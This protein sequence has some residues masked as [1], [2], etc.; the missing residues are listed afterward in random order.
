[1]KR[2]GL[3]FLVL[4]G[5]ASAGTKDNA[6]S[7]KKDVPAADAAIA[8]IPD[9]STR[10]AVADAAAPPPERVSA[11]FPVVQGACPPARAVLIGTTP[12]LHFARA[13]WALP[14]E[15]P[16]KL[17]AQQPPPHYS[18]FVG[19]I[20][21]GDWRLAAL[22]GSNLDHIWY[23]TGSFSERG[24]DQTYL[25]LA[26][27]TLDTPHGE[28]GYFGIQHVLQQP[29][30]SIWAYGHHGMYLDIPGDEKFR[31]QNPPEWKLNRWFAWAKD[32]TPLKDLNLPMGDMEHPQRLDHGEL[33]AVGIS[34]RG[35]A[36]LRR[37]SPT[38]RVDDFTTEEQVKSLPELRVGKNRAVIRLKEK[39]VFYSYDGEARLWNSGTLKGLTSWLVTQDDE[40]WM[41]TKEGE[42][43]IQSKDGASHTEEK[44]PEIGVLASEKNTPWL[45]GSSGAVYE[46]NG[47]DWRKVDVPDGLWSEPTHPANKLE[48]VAVLGRETWISS[49]RT[50]KGFGG[51]NAREVRTF[52][53]S[54]PHAAL[55]CGS[56][57]EASIVAS[58]PPRPDASCAK[59]FVVLG[60]EPERDGKPPIPYAK[61]AAALKGDEVL[62]SLAV[63]SVLKSGAYGMHASSRDKADE[64][65]KKL[66]HV[67]PHEPEIVCDGVA[68]FEAK[69]G[70]QLDV[71]AGAFTLPPDAGAP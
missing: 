43:V 46:R 12:V 58:F 23:T 66:A 65:V 45:M 37:W 49:V 26:G 13:A 51:K 59:L 7:A 28:Y 27:K 15:G 41:T 11:F 20:V 8:A 47:K 35:F 54:K 61:I 39:N 57:F 9:A 30:G 63:L 17:V 16:A 52:Y 69:S 14:A 25:T 33:V 21:G 24:E 56:P 34:E 44:L 4:L 6:S 42:L 64:L 18:Q 3:V 22:G 38:R 68:G 31:G 55:R 62:G 53:A 10:L 40:L 67:T 29:D 50:D 2:R 71:T 19:R 36:Q 1:M 32:G 60:R 70:V 5:C 48:W